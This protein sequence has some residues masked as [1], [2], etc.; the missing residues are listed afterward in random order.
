M[1]LVGLTGGI[2]SGKSSVAA[3]L[4]SRG[5]VVMDA[6]A[7]AREAVD[8]GTPGFDAV[9]DRFG[10]GVVAADGSLDRPALAAIVFRDEEARRDLEAIVHPDVRRRVAESVAAHAG[11]DSILVL[12]SP[13][14]IETGAHRDCD[15]VVV[16]AAEP[17][18]QV[19]RVVGRRMDEPDAR[20]RL[21]A[22]MPLADK[23]EVADV[24]LDNEGTR[25]ELRAQVERLWE[26]LKVRAGTP[27]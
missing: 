8:A 19:R 17:E 26:H 4:A 22:Q 16:V 20:A 6:D 13:L 27:S 10:P 1:L 24:V 14:L 23:A 15:V 3:L 18:T 21:A 5:A 9:V 7:F 25:E 12:D 11:T 2:G